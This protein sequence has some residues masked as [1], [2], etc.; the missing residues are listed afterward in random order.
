VY[1]DGFLLL[2]SDGEVQL[3]A[4]SVLVNGSPIVPSKAGII[5]ST[6]IASYPVLFTTPFANANYAINFAEGA[7][8][9]FDPNTTYTA[10]L[11]TGFTINTHTS[12]AMSVDW[13]ATPY[14]S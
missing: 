4:P 14:N 13:T 3:N 7:P 11:A 12:T 2:E 5:S 8:T 1:G 9:G 10:K 6:G